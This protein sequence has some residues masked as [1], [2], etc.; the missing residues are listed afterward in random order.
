MVYLP[1]HWKKESLLYRATSLIF[2]THVKANYRFLIDNMTL[3]IPVATPL[4][5][6]L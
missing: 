3:I 5:F 1:T 2:E 6:I 4:T